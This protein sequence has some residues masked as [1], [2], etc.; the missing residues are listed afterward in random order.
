MGAILLFLIAW[1]IA[2]MVLGEVLPVLFELLGYA[3]CYLFECFGI[4]L[5][6]LFIWLFR[7]IAWLVRA[8]WCG[9]LSLILRAREAGE[10]P[11]PE[12][13][14]EAEAEDADEAEDTNEEPQPAP[15]PAPDPYQAARHLL[16]LE[17]GFSRTA[18]SRAYKQAMKHAHPDAGGT[19]RKAQAVNAARE[20]LM[21]AHGW[22]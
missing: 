18:L 5:K 11:A 22:A 1:C 13:K 17:S 6:Y 4:A 7:G 19:T 14:V 8:S 15:R 9:V 20:L 3:L 10:G 12:D 21:R 2:C 16:G